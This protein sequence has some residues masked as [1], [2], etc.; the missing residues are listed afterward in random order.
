[1]RIDDLHILPKVRDSG[2][3]LYLERGQ[4][5]Q[6]ERSVAFVNERGRVPIPVANVSLLLLGPGTS[7]THRAIV[8]AT[9]CGCS[10]AWAGEE[11][12]RLYAGGLG[13]TRSARRLIRQ[14]E[15]V[16]DPA[17]RLAVIRRMYQ[18]RF[19]DPLPANMTLR[20]IRGREG[21]RV[22]DSYRAWSRETGI[23]WRGRNYSR[24][25]WSRGDP[26]NRA[27]S[28]ANSCL[29]GVCHAA[30]VSAGYSTG[31]GFIHSGKSLSFVYDVAD[32]YKTETAAPAAFLAVQSGLVDVERAARHR[33]RDQF[34][35]TRLLSRIVVDIAKVLEIEAD[36]EE[37]LAPG[38]VDL[39]S[40]LARPGA[41]WD[42]SGSASGGRNYADDEGRL[43]GPDGALA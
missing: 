18:L 43:D 37:T 6:D 30:I 13:D 26:I 34:H 39:D 9:E 40:D 31:L 21:A 32:L 10:V 33:L 8:N 15:L 25:D 42:P 28:A 17:D 27:M 35:T 23:E 12:V 19:Q 14:A 2:S 5:E 22:R 3:F 4:L 38:E 29:Y 41:L 24:E 11:G 1:M 20:Q 16:A 36:D 7:V